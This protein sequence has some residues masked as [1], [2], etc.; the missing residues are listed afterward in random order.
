MAQR[1]LAA[2]MFSDIVGYTSLMGG[3]EQKAFDTLKKNR[4]IHWRLI[5]KYRGRFLKEMGDGTLA[6]FSSSVDAI[7]CATSIQLAAEE[8]DIPLRIGLHQGDVIFEKNDVLGDGVNIASRIQSV[9]ETRGIAIS[10][11]IYRD[12]RNKEGLEVVSLG[13]QSLK[14][15]K[16]PMGVYKLSCTDQGILD[17]KIDTGELLQ[18]LGSRRKSVFAV[19]LIATLLIMV[20][21]AIMTNT[22]YIKKQD[23]SV[24]VMPFNDYTG[25]DDLNYV[26]SGMHDEL[27]VNIGRIGGLRVLGKTTA[28]AYK[29]TEKPLT[30]IGRER[31]VKTIIEGALRCFGEDSICFTAKVI[32]VYPKERQ[33]DA[34]DFKVARSEFPSLYNRITK[35]FTK[36]IDLILTPAEEKFLA[37]SRTV[38]REVYD[39]YLRS[40]QYW[41]DAS[42]E[43]LT[44][45]RQY[46]TNALEKD[47]TWAPLYSGLAKVWIGLNQMGFESPEIAV[48]KIYENINKALEL[49]PD[50]GDAHYLNALIAYLAEWNWEKSEREFLDAIAI[51]PNDAYARIYYSHL[52]F[53]LQR[54]DEA[55]R[56]AKLAYENDPLNPT[57]L[58]TY[59][60]ALRC[61]YDFKSSL[62]YA[63]KA[64]ELDPENF[65]AMVQI[66]GS[67]YRAL[68]Y[69]KNLE[70]EKF[71]LQVYSK[72]QYEEDDLNDVDQV[73]EEQGFYASFG[74]ILKLYEEL[75]NQGL[76]SHGRMASRYIMGNKLD[77][78]L[79]C[80]EKA[81]EARDS[82]MPYIATGGYPYHPLYANSRF[83]AI[84]KKMNLPMP[85]K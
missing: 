17:Y 16:S 43:S 54:H 14:G 75:Y 13:N 6:S 22:G 70:A 60:F 48:P 64:L 53:I 76:V 66:G 65:L 81:F 71:S 52:L 57:I 34:Q 26:I 35:E 38:D 41:D 73:F 77:E 23:N 32:E 10:E 2:I 42:L 55:I 36:A 84:L 51:K 58:V 25:I 31:G 80:L 61:A 28:D 46:L 56:Q 1:K 11:T 5:K 85:K 74:E 78:A 82:H 39:A 45:A 59:S 30:E 49:D 50:H 68:D 19:L 4:R 47:S 8:L 18:P 3:D 37:K 67:A 63:E 79:E 20:V 69:K 83:I 12:I 24:L 21:Y 15:V 44:K 62:L 9:A 29:N 40:H 27:I 33:L 7:M 72:D